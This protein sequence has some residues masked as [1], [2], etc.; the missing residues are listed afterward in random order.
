MT[1]DTPSSV[2]RP[3]T[4][5]TDPLRELE[6]HFP[7]RQCGIEQWLRAP[8]L[9]IPASFCAP[10]NSGRWPWPSLA[11]RRPEKGRTAESSVSE[12]KSVKQA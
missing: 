10:V 1:H 12:P 3:A 6:G 9:S 8:R 4:A 11:R 5:L 7:V 2:P